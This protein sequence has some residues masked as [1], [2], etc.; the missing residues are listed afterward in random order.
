MSV[1][2]CSRLG[3]LFWQGVHRLQGQ[4]RPRTGHN[5]IKKKKKKKKN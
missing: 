3:L 5:R 4:A 1:A 2:E